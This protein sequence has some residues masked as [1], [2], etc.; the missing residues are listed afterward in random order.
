MRRDVQ[1]LG[2]SNLTERH[3]GRLAFGEQGRAW[4]QRA[5]Q[6]SCEDA[7]AKAVASY[8]ELGQLTSSPSYHDRL[9]LSYVRLGREDLAKQEETWLAEYNNVAE[10]RSQAMEK[11]SQ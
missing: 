9:R 3:L 11:Q 5:Q 1:Q 10:E 4:Q 6:Q 2:A 8:Q 7:V